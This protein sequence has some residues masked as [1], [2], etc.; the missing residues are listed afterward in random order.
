MAEKD[1]YDEYQFTDIDTFGEENLGEEENASLTEEGLEKKP[2]SKSNLRR[3]VFVA[4]FVI[5]IIMLGYKFISRFIHKSAPSPE[6]VTSPPLQPTGFQS[7]QPA[8]PVKPV[9]QEAPP[10]TPAQ[11]TAPASEKLTEDNMQIKQKLSDLEA[12]QQNVR[13]EVSTVSNQLSGINTN[14][15][16]LTEKIANLNQIIASLSSKLEEQSHEIVV[17]TERS[18]PRPKK[19]RHRP[20]GRISPGPSYFIQAVIPG[21]AWL[22][23]T[24]GSTIT[25]REGSAIPGYGIVQ[26]IDPNQGRVL[27][28]SG[29][30][31]GFSQQDS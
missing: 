19:M 8:L 31:I 15:S 17:L 10:L 24:N 18:K 14:V 9:T 1:Q 12:S 28:S 25:V 20:R 30:V 6:I 23:A 2:P 21:R 22:I 7:A 5:I 27:T 16:Q 29:Q 11:S 13:N 26:L 3:N 4:I